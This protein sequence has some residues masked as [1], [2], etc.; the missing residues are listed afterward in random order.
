MRRV[1]A[2][3]I[4]SGRNRQDLGG[5]EFHAEA[6]RL[7]ALNDNVNRPFDHIK[8]CEET[9]RSTLQYHESDTRSDVTFITSLSDLRPP[10]AAV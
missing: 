10:P 6:A 2:M 5:T 4:E 1:I 8:P 7:T 9:L 3:G